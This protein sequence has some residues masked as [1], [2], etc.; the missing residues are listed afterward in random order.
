MCTIKKEIAVFNA[1]KELKNNED[2]HVCG[3][4]P[5]GGT[6]NFNFSSRASHSELYNY[7]SIIKGIKKPKDGF[8]LRAESF[9]NLATIIEELNKGGRRVQNH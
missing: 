1:E 2:T 4:N 9:Y 6:K 3:F 5:E 7:I 8:F